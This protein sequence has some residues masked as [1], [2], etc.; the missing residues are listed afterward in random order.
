[1]D[2]SMAPANMWQR[3]ALTGINGRGGPGPVEA[4]CPSLEG[5]YRSEA[6]AGGWYGKH[7]LRSKRDEGSDGGLRRRDHVGGQHL[8]CNKIK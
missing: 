5:C 7:L 1:M 8:K 4:C 3:I 6:G 2:R